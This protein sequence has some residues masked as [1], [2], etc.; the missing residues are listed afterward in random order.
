MNSPE[1]YREQSKWYKKLSR[2]GF[3]D[4]EGGKDLTCTKLMMA[5]QGDST[6]MSMNAVQVR[7]G[8]PMQQLDDFS[9]GS[10]WEELISDQ[11]DVDAR[12]SPSG[13]Y[14]H[15]AQLIVSQEYELRRLGEFRTASRQRL[16]WALHAQ[17]VSEREIARHCESS[18]HQIRKYIAELDAMVHTAIDMADEL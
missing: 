9:Q 3:F 11:D 14:M 10:E 17:G 13:V 2:R 8:R 1:F 15:Y 6:M 18:R 4:I 5:P 16:A 7:S 12:R